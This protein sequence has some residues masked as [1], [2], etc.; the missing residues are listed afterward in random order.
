MEVVPLG[1]NTQPL[2]LVVKPTLADM[3]KSAVGLA[4]QKLRTEVKDEKSEDFT[5][6]T[7]GSLHY[8]SRWCVQKDMELRQEIRTKAHQSPYT[9]HLDGTK[10]TRTTVPRLESKSMVARN[11]S[12]CRT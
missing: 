4:L 3:I 12:G 9:A 6:H 7:D 11:E 1:A 8:Q 10:C 2:T 5:I